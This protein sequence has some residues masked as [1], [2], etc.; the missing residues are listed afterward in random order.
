MPEQPKVEL[1]ITCRECLEPIYIKSWNWRYVQELENSCRYAHTA[2]KQL[3]ES[4]KISGAYK[5]YIGTMGQY[6]T[7]GNICAGIP[8]KTNDK[9]MGGR[10]N[11]DNQNFKKEQI[12]INPHLILLKSTSGVDFLIV[13]WYINNITIIC[14]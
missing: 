14:F 8:V 6:E 5:V 13:M 7:L 2:L 4:N 11:N 3:I 9:I 10:W 1:E 12:E